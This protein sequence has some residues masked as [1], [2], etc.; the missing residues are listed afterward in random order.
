MST[1]KAFNSAAFIKKIE[2]LLKIRQ[3]VFE[4]ELF[5]TGK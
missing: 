4:G 1:R 5:F 3:F 2:S